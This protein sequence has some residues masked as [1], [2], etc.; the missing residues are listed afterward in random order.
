MGLQADVAGVVC[1]SR[2]GVS[3][4]SLVNWVAGEISK[5]N[6]QALCNLPNSLFSA[7]AVLI[8]VIGRGQDL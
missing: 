7:L 1:V 2:A 5:D 6:L 8:E 3:T 4:G